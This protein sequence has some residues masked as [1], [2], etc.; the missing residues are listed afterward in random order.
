MEASLPSWREL[1]ARLLKRVAEENRA[2]KND[3]AKQEWVRRSLEQDDL[4]AAGAV[5]EVMAREDLDTLLPQELYG[6]EGPGGYE[7]GPIAQQVAY[8]RQCYGERLVVLTTNYD[9]L[10]ERALLRR[11]FLNRNIKSYVR[12]R[13]ALPADAVPVTHL[14]GFAGRTGPPKRLVL[15]EEHYHRMQTGS[16]WQE[17]LATERL[18]ESLCLFV[19]TS[20]TDPNLIR[21]LYG[22]KKAGRQHAAIFVRQG[23]LE[24]ADDSVRAVR[25][26]AVSRRWER[27]G[28]EA[29]FVD[30]FAD[31]AQLVYEIGLRR[32]QGEDY[33][34][35]GERAGRVISG[36]EDIVFAAKGEKDAFATRQVVLSAWIRA[37]LYDTLEVATRGAGPE[38]DEH[39]AVALWLLGED[40]T[41]ITGWV[42]S[43]RAHQDLATVEAVPIASASDWVAVRAVCQGVRVE[44]DRDNPVSRWRF[45]RGLPVVFD[46]PT[47]LP[48]GCL[49]VSSTKPGKESVLT[50]LPESAKAEFHRGLI[51]PI[52]RTF[53]PLLEALA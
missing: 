13:E 49:T 52:S 21:Y 41:T 6:P 47:R 16:S 29:V 40:G 38:D 10:I 42:H 22:Y 44:L 11:G 31:A 20:L 45:V 34:P 51:E 53:A 14:H 8:L 39:L 50:K 43:D 17:E 3:E 26:Q 28:V 30:H 5:V 33:E 18:S 1:V 37:L 12:R 4:L 7:P 15:T 25:E 46:S 32:E 35:T 2:L 48:V 27:Q 23:D 19:G 24:G 9:D 36:I